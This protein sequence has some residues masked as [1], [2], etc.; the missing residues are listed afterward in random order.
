MAIFDLKTFGALSGRGGGLMS[1]LGTSFGMPSCLLNLTKDLMSA[2]PGPV[3]GG[4]RDTAQAGANRAD[5]VIKGVFQKLRWDSGHMEWNSED[6]TISWVSDTSKGGVDKNEGSLLDTI[7]GAMGAVEAAAGFAG[8]LYTNIENGYNK[9]QAAK[10][11]VNS[12]LNYL[13]FSGGNSAAEKERLAQINPQAF[14]D[15]MADKWAAEKASLT[16]ALAFQDSVNNLVSDIDSVLGDRAKDPTLEPIY[17]SD[18]AT[19][20]SGTLLIVD[21]PAGGTTAAAS[22][23]EIFRLIFGPPKSSSGRFI[24]SQD[25]LYFDSQVSGITP[26][27]L[28]VSYQTSAIPDSEKWKFKQNPNLGG[29]GEGFSTRELKFYIDSVLDPSIIDESTFYEEHYDAD[30]L[31]QDLI[32]QRNKRIY[33]LSSQIQQLVINDDSESL[34][35]N[36]RQALLSENS[37]H[38]E[39]INKR[40]KQ[41]E[42]A[43]KLPAI[44]AG[45]ELPTLGT[46][47]VN[48]FSYL[49]GINLVVDIQKQ[50]AMTLSQVEI[51]GVVL[52]LLNPTYVI[53][54][55]HS[56]Q[57]VMEHLII[58]GLGDGAIIYDGSSVLEVDPVVLQLKNTLT[59]DSLFAM[60]NFLD[61]NIEQT[62]STIFSVRNSA[63]N[64][65]ELYAQLVGVDAKSVFINGLGIPYF[66][67][68]TKHSQTNPENPIGVGSYMKLPK[69]KKFDDFLYNK[70]GA[71][72]DFWTHL[73]NLSV[74]SNGYDDGTVTGLYRLVLANE[75][76]GTQSSFSDTTGGDI[77]NTPNI[78]SSSRVR[79]FIMGFTRDQRITQGLSA[80]FDPTDNKADKSVFFIAPTQSLNLSTIIIPNRS[81]YDLGDCTTN[82]TAGYKFHCMS[83]PVSSIVSGVSFS[84]CGENY[85]H[86]AVTFNPEKDEINFYL[87]GN[88]VTTSSMSFVFGIPKYTMPKLPTLKTNNSFE[89]STNSVG[90]EA[91]D[92]LKSGPKLNTFF[93]PWI[94]GG[95]YTDGMAAYGGFM[96]SLYG[97]LI[98][99]LRGNLGSLKFYTKPLD[100]EEVYNN[101]ICHKDF[102]KNI[103]TKKSY[104]EPILDN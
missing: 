55:Q 98:S 57:T 96:G 6:G 70:N 30:G 65:Q 53:P 12:Y 75:N 99:G 44:Y 37:A 43:I 102:F 32:G 80:S 33:D 18:Y 101:Y 16:G 58:P 68:I 7:K 46:I 52:P 35:F 41:I 42:L 60:Y 100:L 81:F 8:R 9:F 82:P 92:Q 20:L 24:M 72:I 48:N 71:T 97:G 85:C 61:T 19:L 103:D 93:T 67:G 40:K 104:W 10:N 15:I 63:S 95:G 23:K 78:F 27:L 79:G 64:T 11:C 13:K 38:I 76:V 21:V 94:V 62:S 73:P 14:E 45:K 89:Y 77:L 74:N 69:T 28:E 88:R 59:T 47:P 49:E 51:S 90:L 2:I 3:L 36:Y 4:M 83:H 5:D 31:L 87:D 86:I 26:A 66:E 29:R 34:I 25:G 54:I 84:S 17:T 39:N 1:S 50:R 22:R 91:S 56:K